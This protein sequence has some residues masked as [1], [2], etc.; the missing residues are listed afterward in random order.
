MCM[1]ALARMHTEDSCEQ[2]TAEAEV[3]QQ[4]GEGEP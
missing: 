3:I 1:H 4:F 2:K